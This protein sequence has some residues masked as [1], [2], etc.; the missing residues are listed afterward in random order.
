VIYQEPEIVPGVGVAENIWVG[1]LPQRAA[2]S[3][4]RR[5]ND[6]VRADLARYGF[7]HALPTRLMGDE[8]SLPSAS[9]S[10]SCGPSEQRPR[11]RP[12]RAQPRR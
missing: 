3:N 11:P 9:W 6:L 7:E 1:E 10:R 8:L 4:R 12:R 2:S 5:L